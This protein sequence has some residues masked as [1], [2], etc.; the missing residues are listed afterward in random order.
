MK[1]KFN[2]RYETK[3]GEVLFLVIE[4]KRISMSYTPGAIWQVEHEFERKTLPEGLEY[5]YELWQDGSRKRREWK[6]HVLTS[7]YESDA[8]IDAP[9]NAPFT[10]QTLKCAGTAIPLFS[11]RTQDSFGVGDFHDLKKLADWVYATGQRVIQLLPLNDTTTTGTWVDSYPYSANSIYALHPQFIYLPDIGVV[12]DDDY[13]KLRKELESMPKLDYERVNREKDRLMR[14]AF[15]SSW[16]IVSKQADFKKFIKGNSF[17]LTAYCAYRILTTEYGSS[18]PADWGE[19]AKYSKKLANDVVKENK[20]EADYHSFVQYHLSKQLK[21]ASEYIRAKGM[22]LKGDLPIGVSRASVDAWQNPKQFHMDSQAG[23]PP[24]AFSIDGQNWAFPTYN[25]DKMAEDGY[26]WWRERLHNM[27]QYFDTFRID[28]ILGFFRIWEIPCGYKSGLMGHFNPSLPYS[29]AELKEKGFDLSTGKYTEPG[30]IDTLFLEDPRKKGYWHPR[31]MAM[32]TNKYAAMSEEMK[33]TFV[34]LHDDFFYR[35][36]NEFWKESAMKKLPEL[37]ACTKMFACGEDLG[38]IPACVPEV[39]SELGIL[40]LEIQRMPKE[41]YVNFADTWKYPYMSVCATST[42]DMN[43]LRAWWREDKRLS[44]DFWNHVLGQQGE[45]PQECTPEICRSIIMMHLQSSSAMA[46]LPLQDYLSLFPKLCHKKPEDERVN[47]P[48][49]TPYNWRYR[50]KVTIEDL[51]SHEITP[52]LLSL[53]QECGR[54]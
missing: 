6:N 23:A 10:S 12:Q 9:D 4:G 25:W 36:H 21:E 39:M 18:N 19:Y 54:K 30:S 27:E 17:W 7:A 34:A 16:K 52:Y 32:D 41:S 11:V 26:A 2:I 29:E 50:M 15:S 37:L 33:N 40:S 47:I 45:A 3:W 43:P 31:I 42:H 35:R 48:S 14:M 1:I 44:R 20:A 49:I 38:M 46:I 5:H 53:M 24:D 8:W 13:I 22:M 28:H 51:L